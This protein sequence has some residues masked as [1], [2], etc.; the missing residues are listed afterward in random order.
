MHGMLHRNVKRPP[1]QAD[2]R[3]RVRAHLEQGYE[4]GRW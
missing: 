1:L 4:I 2:L 3:P